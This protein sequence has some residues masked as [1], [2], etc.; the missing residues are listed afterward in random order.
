MERSCAS[1]A[2]AAWASSS[3]GARAVIDI[4]TDFAYGDYRMADLRTRPEIHNPEAAQ[5]LTRLR[6]AFQA[7]KDQ[8]GPGSYQQLAGI[9]GL[10]D[11]QCLH[12]VPGWLPWHRLYVLQ[13]E[14]ALRTIDA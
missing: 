10:P 2:A 12:H 7:L 1:S 3:S 4:S 9:H 8:Q 5:I 11:F 6:Q 13:V 14:E